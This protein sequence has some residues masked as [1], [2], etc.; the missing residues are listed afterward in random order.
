M[1][2]SHFRKY[3]GDGPSPYGDGGQ[4]QSQSNGERVIA[5]TKNVTKALD[6]GVMNT[7]PRR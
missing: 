3:F 1:V 5:N 6:D 7:R 4:Q 2:A